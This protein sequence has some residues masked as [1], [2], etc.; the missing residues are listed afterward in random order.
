MTGW[1]LVEGRC[2]F[3]NP[4]F[5]SF[6][7]LASV[8]YFLYAL[9]C[10]LGALFLLIYTFSVSL[11]IKKNKGRKVVESTAKR[12]PSSASHTERELRS[13]PL[14][15]ISKEEKGAIAGRVGRSWSLSVLAS[16][17]VRG[18]KVER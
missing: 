8:V 14:I 16:A 15:S 3:L 6:C 4:S 9:G 10:P 18:W 17:K 13:A 5:F 1:A 7:L 11:P 2:V 12:K